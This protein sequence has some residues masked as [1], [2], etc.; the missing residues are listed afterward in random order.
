MALKDLFVLV[1]GEFMFVHGLKSITVMQLSDL[2]A[3]G[4]FGAFFPY[5]KAFLHRKETTQERAF[6]LVSGCSVALASG[7]CG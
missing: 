6:P 2:G 3:D 4:L 7:L 1:L 5:L